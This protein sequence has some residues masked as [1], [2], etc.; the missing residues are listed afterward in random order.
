MRG[1][2]TQMA[3]NSEHNKPPPP[4]WTYLIELGRPEDDEED[5]DD[6]GIEEMWSRKVPLKP[7]AAASRPAN[8]RKSIGSGTISKALSRLPRGSR[9]VSQCHRNITAPSKWIL[10]PPPPP[11]PLFRQENNKASTQ[12][13]TQ[14]NKKI[15]SQALAPTRRQ[16]K[17]DANVELL[18]DPSDVLR[19][20]DPVPAPCH[21]PKHLV[22]DPG[23][24]TVRL[25][26]KARKQ[27]ARTTIN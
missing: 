9:R 7:S 23:V 18:E 12:T 11:P 2:Q 24:E 1:D 15:S 10:P 13:R 22:Q 4:V 25:C 3:T 21:H 8:C 14:T 27:G 5:D 20:D 19:R 16:N 26:S 6:I 17:P